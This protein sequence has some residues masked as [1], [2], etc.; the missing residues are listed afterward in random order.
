MTTEHT[1]WNYRLIWDI[2]LW[3]IGAVLLIYLAFGS[4]YY[5]ALHITSQAF[6]G[7]NEW[8]QVAL[9]YAVKFILTIPIW[10]LLFRKL[11]LWSLK[12]RL[13]IHVVALPVFAFLFRILFY[14]LCEVFNFGH[15]GEDGSFWDIYIPSLFYC[16][17]FGVFHTYDFYHRFKK[18]Q[19]KQAELQALALQSELRALKAQINPHFL[20]NTFNTISASLSPKQEKTREMIAR[21]SDMFRYQLYVSQKELVSTE[22]EIAFAQKY[23]ELEKE[24]FGDRLHYKIRLAPEASQSKI[25]PMLLQPLVE[26]AVKHGIAPLIE[27]GSIEI[28]VVRLAQ[29]VQFKVNDTGAGLNG[30][31]TEELLNKGIGLSNT[32]R[33]LQRMYGKGLTFEDGNPQGLKVSFII[34]AGSQ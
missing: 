18:E 33:R 24:R 16:L 23:L 2:K 14:E 17:Q 21:L 28:S 4:F 34:P 31:Q 30:Y 29:G 5:G 32:E 6:G 13:A 27:G 10:W 8:R 15:L 9:N 19:Q 1:F 12:Y 3:E 26:N 20:Y 7:F 22:E 11:A 25:P